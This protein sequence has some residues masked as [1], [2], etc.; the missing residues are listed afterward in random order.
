[1]TID[2]DKLTQTVREQVGMVDRYDYPPSLAVFTLPSGDSSIEAY[3]SG[4]VEASW[5]ETS[6]DRALLR[7]VL[8]AV[9]AQEGS[10]G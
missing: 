10:G 6:D 2:L 8:D 3:A 4:R 7:A 9:D 1:M 5:I